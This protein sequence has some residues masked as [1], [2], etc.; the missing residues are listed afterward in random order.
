MHLDGVRLV[1]GSG[2]AA[3]EVLRGVDLALGPG[4]LVALAGRSGSGKS[5]LCHLV[6]GVARPSAGTVR[7]AGHPAHAVRDWGTVALL[8]QRLALVP[9]LSLAEN[10]LLPRRLG[11]AGP[12][13]PQDGAGDLLDRLGVARVAHRP[14]QEASLGEQQ[15][16]ALARALHAG[17]AVAVLDEPTGHQ[18]DD[19]VALVLAAVVAAARRGTLVLVATHDE[20]VSGAADA[21]VRLHDG[22]VEAVEGDTGAPPPA[23]P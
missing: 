15:R 16:A 23:A 20:R 5:S 8:P 21:R 2:A 3:T 7:V 9:E 22:A 17:P 18:D 6:A 10:V 11:R 19:H 1:R 4:R 12:C 13:A 14:A